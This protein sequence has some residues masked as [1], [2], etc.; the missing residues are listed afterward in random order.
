MS[1]RADYGISSLNPMAARRAL[2][3]LHPGYPL[4]PFDRALAEDVGSWRCNH[5]ANRPAA[6][7]CAATSSPSSPASSP[8]WTSPSGVPGGRSLRCVRF[9]RRRRSAGGAAREP[10]RGLRPGAGAADRGS[11]PRSTFSAA[12]RASPRSHVSSWTRSPAPGR[13]ILDTRKTAPGLRLVDKLAV[14]E[15]GGTNHRIGLF[16][17]IL[18]KDNHIDFAG[19]L[20]EAVERARVGGGEFQHRGRSPNARGRAGGSRSGGRTHPAGQHERRDD[21]RRGGNERR[22]RRCWKPPA[23]S[24]WRTCAASPRPAWISSPSAR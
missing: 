10:G 4:R 20:D 16:D 13:S 12:C 2:D 8:G 18:I 24:T 17:M 23:T 14:A 7:A 9:G 6:A 21:V 1:P 11:A 19:G 15:G 3:A 5:R 22:P